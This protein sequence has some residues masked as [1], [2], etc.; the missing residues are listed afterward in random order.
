[1]KILKKQIKENLLN[2]LSMIN[3][4]LKKFLSRWRIFGSRRRLD[5]PPNAVDVSDGRVRE[6]GVPPL[7]WLPLMVKYSA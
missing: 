3:R 7:G 4:V 1:M 2:I 6:G 5:M